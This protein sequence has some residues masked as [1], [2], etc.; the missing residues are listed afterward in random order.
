MTYL[1][2]SE[3]SY[4]DSMNL[5]AFWRLRVSNQTQLA[6]LKHL[7]DKL[8]LFFDEVING[9]W[10][11]THSVATASVN[12]TVANAWDYVIRQTKR[13]Y[14]YFA[15]KSQ[16]VPMTFSGN[17]PQ[18]GVEKEVWYF[19]S[20]SVAPYTA[21][22]DG[23][24][25]RNNW[26]DI[27]VYTYR[28]GTI[29][30]QAT[31]WAWNIDN[32][33]WTWPSGIT[34]DW[35]LDQIFVID[36]QYLGVGRVRLG[37]SLNWVVYPF[38]EFDNA[39]NLAD[40]YMSSPNHSIRYSI[41]S[42]GGA[43]SFKQ[44]CSA[45]ST[46]WSI[47]SLIKPLSVNR[48]TSLLTASTVGTRYASQVVRLASWFEDANVIVSRHSI[49]SLSNDDL[50]RELVFNPTI[51][52]ALVYWAVTDTAIEHAV[53][54]TANTVTGGFVMA[55]GYVSQFTKDTNEILLSLNLWS[56]INGTRDTIALV[57]TPLSAGA[58]LCSALEIQESL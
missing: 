34:V 19:N 48:G 47:N 43:G 46:E 14:P 32:M 26:T 30:N 39:N 3:I 42:T 56:N 29:T 18:A 45:V 22:L 58:T 25:M 23:I 1:P 33:D 53:G 6:D 20:S 28:S 12:M 38:H 16:L 7:K 37:L 15:G 51:A 11:S 10:T 17:Q 27:T 24:L 9:T 50:R 40:V 44:I 57:I 52:G 31:Q 21:S 2:V 13:R 5:D 41:R 35:S 55:S 54:A 8:P 4:K 49:D 36:F